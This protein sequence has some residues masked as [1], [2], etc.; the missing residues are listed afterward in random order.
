MRIS[1]GP[2]ISVSNGSK[3]RVR[4]RSRVRTAVATAFTTWKTGPGPLPGRFQQVQQQMFSLWESIWVLMVLQYDSY[5]KYAVFSS[6]SPPG[7]RFAIQSILVEL[8]WNYPKNYA[9]ST[10]TQRILIRSQ[11][12]DRDVIERQKLNLLYIDHIAIRS[13]VKYWIGYKLWD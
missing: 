12:G 4:V 9:F 11:I 3:L 13:E 10:V 7:L 2:R 6:R 5:V 1:I 8:Q